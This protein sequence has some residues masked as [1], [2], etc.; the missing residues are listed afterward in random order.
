METT[1]PRI[2]IVD[3]E[4]FNLQYL[5]E[6][7]QD[8]YDVSLAKNGTK[9]L[10]LA[11]TLLPDLIILDVI[12]TG[13]DGY[14][15]IRELKSSEPTMHIP[16]IFLTSLSN[17]VDEEK[18]LSL[19]ALDYISKPFHP[20]IVKARVTN[21]LELGRHRKLLEKIALLDG[22]TGIPNRRA[23]D[24]RLEKEWLR[25]CRNGDPFSLAFV[26]IDFFK[27]Y[28]DTYGHATGDKALHKVAQTLSRI[29]RRSSDFVARYGGEE[30]AIV[31][32][33]MSFQNAETFATHASREI[34]NL[35]MEHSASAAADIVTI[36]IGGA[37]TV[38]SRSQRITDFLAHVDKM[39]Y[40]AKETRNTAVWSF[41]K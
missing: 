35:N 25:S 10:H 23:Y 31:L 6:L 39:L 5:A 1:K 17:P 19:G 2:L 30:F 33:N 28:N 18:G 14:A 24:E 8:D 40:K 12:M 38:P 3:D 4:V 13:M 29:L 27:Q 22:L 26:D 36:S 7:L 20:V 11:R 15:V 16:V 9:A 21:I 34:A 37:T 32:P 41:Y